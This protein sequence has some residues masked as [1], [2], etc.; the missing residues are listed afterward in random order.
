M[1]LK[2]PNFCDT[3][4]V[5]NTTSPLPLPLKARPPHC[6]LSFHPTLSHCLITSLTSPFHN[7]IPLLHC[8]TTSLSHNTMASLPHCLTATLPH[9]PTT[10]QPHCLT[11]TPPHYATC[12][13]YSHLHSPALR[14]HLSQS[15]SLPTSLPHYP[16]IPL[17]H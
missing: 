5:G 9:G 15:H 14:P 16:T 17:P 13:A 4:P 10:P 3:V 1:R 7:T 2:C 12:L 8:P 6:L 11:T